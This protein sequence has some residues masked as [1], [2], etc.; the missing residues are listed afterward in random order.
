MTEPLTIAHMD[1]FEFLHVRGAGADAALEKIAD[2]VVIR[3]GKPYVIHLSPGHP[4]L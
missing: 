4:P 2:D 3:G 1:T